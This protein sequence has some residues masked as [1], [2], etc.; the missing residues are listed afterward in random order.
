MGLSE[1]RVVAPVV[2]GSES[3]KW[4]KFAERRLVWLMVVLFGLLQVWAHRNDMS[5]DGISYIEL[6]H[7][8]VAFGL[9]GLTNAYWSPLYPFLIGVTF[10]LFHPP[11]AWEFTAVHFLNFVIY[12]ASFACFRVLLKRLEK[13]RGLAA[14]T[15]DGFAHAEFR[16]TALLGGVL[17]LWAA[18]FWL[19]PSLVNPDLCVAALMYLA[20]AVLL[21]I[22]RKGCGVPTWIILG[23][24]LGVAYLAKAAMFLVGFVFLGCAFFLARR[25]QSTRRAVLEMLVGLAMFLVVA[26]PWIMALSDAKGRW[27][28]GDS[29]KIA[30]AEYVNHAT[31]TTHWQGLPVGTGA[32]RHPTREILADPAMYEFAQPIPGSYPPWRD[33]SYW[34]DGIRAHFELRGQLWVMFRALNMYFKMFSK[35][36]ALYVVLIALL[37]AVHRTGRWQHVAPEMW[38]VMLP[39]LA[40]L[41]MY[42]LVWV[43]FRYVSP[44]VLMLLVWTFSRVELASSADVRL[45]RRV[46]LALM[47]APLV[48]ILW[49][50][51]RDTGSIL[52]DQPDEDWQVATAL[53]GLGV[54]T[55]AGVGY[56]GSGLDAYWAY[57]AGDRIIAEIPGRDQSAFI[58][59][60]QEKKYAILQRFKALGAK[61]VITKNAGVAGSMSGWQHIGA[62]RYYIWRP[63]EQ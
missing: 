5:P 57:L 13:A 44:F 1:N 26:T 24:I 62:T 31:L 25:K 20:T 8:Y 15:S 48:A 16:W 50:L 22:L 37:W 46:G 47:L 2:G 6:A 18:Q 34:Y 61:A 45:L 19:S 58:S 9:P 52:R 36:G 49:P 27:T 51:L 54:A 33:P 39:P 40:A 63:G 59:T 23:G 41:A 55:G 28:F 3:Q 60:E 30:Y 7:S 14:Q 4:A 53:P 43:E 11:I 35:S 12:I 10:G 42:A 29:G 32:P 17:F 56:I 21:R 38:L